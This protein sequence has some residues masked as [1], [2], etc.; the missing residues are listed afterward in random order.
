MPAKLF[1]KNTNF[2]PILITSQI[3]LVISIFY[4]LFIFFTMV[5]NT[6][7]GL[8]LHID[9]ILSSDSF[10]FQSTYG[11]CALTAS[12]STYTMLTL[13][14]I[15]IIEKANKI[16]DYALTTFFLHLILTT[17]NSQFPL[18]LIWWIINGSLLSLA[19]V[20]S[21]YISLK[22]DQKDITLDFKVFEKV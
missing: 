18:N 3:I 5:Y 21:E 16:L 7:F 15:I 8:Q 19:T 10:D 22:I 9:Q 20:I 1:S 14:F 6:L 2:N 13:V 11:Y 4:V 17:L 12:L